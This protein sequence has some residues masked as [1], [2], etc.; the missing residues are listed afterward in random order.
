MSYDDTHC[1]LF[2]FDLHSYAIEL[3][4]VSTTQIHPSPP[5]STNVK[6]KKQT[7][8]DLGISFPHMKVHIKQNWQGECPS[9]VQ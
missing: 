6:H 2:C 9:N 8:I 1:S 4:S 3:L 5:F 7:F